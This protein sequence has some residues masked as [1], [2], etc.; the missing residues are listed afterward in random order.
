MLWNDSLEIGFEVIDK[1][2]ND[3]IAR[4]EAMMYAES[5]KERLA[6]FETFEKIVENYFERE[7]A[8]HRICNFFDSEKHKQSHEVYLKMLKRVKKNL[9]E[10]GATLESENIF[11]KNTFEYLKKHILCH[12]QLF[13]FF[14][15]DDMIHKGITTQYR[16]VP[17]FV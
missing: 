14:C 6:Q 8:I 12:D 7:Q 3:L 15:Q 16:V 11:R 4:V 2:N 13:G 9:T 5:S 17:S 10:E 1:Q